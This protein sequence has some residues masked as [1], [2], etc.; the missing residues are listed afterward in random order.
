MKEFSEINEALEQCCQLALRQ[1]QPGKQ[2]VLMS[3]VC[4]N[5]NWCK[6][7]LS[8]VQFFV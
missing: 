7:C 2:L 1:P 3:C 4:N 8:S 5:Q 6:K